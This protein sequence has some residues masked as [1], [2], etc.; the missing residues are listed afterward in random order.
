MRV[1]NSSNCDP[2]VDWLR[3]KSGMDAIEPRAVDGKVHLVFAR[4]TGL[5]ETAVRDA[6]WY[7]DTV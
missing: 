7:F 5:K 1:E 6:S 2:M 4:D 3:A